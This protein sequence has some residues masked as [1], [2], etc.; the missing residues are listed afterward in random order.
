MK[1][2][3]TPNPY[4]L[5]VNMKSGCTALPKLTAAAWLTLVERRVAADAKVQMQNGSTL[6]LE[7]LGMK[8]AMLV[9]TAK[10]KGEMTSGST[11]SP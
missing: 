1:S 8:S 6:S 3:S 10:K 11:P 5:E 4:A 2:G 7:E 9:V